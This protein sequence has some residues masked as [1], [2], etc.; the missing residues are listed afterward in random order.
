MKAFPG[1]ILFCLSICWIQ[2]SELSIVGGRAL[3]TNLKLDSESRA[4]TDYSLLGARFE[5]DFL[6]ILGFENS[7]IYGRKMLTPVGS[8][9]SD[10]LYYNA[11]F[12]LNFSSASVAPNLALGIGLMYRFGNTYP[13]SGLSFLTSM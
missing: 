11:A 13:K 8:E 9:G 10:G 12:V 7:L 3:P 1:A 6:F 4:M 2:A 5:K